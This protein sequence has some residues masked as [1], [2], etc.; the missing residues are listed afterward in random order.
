MGNN[1]E[2]TEELIKDIK[3]AVDKAVGRYSKKMNCNFYTIGADNI[4]ISFR[5]QDTMQIDW[6]IT[7]N[8]T[9]RGD[10]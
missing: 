10:G 3:E 4:E 9:K 6:K 7:A 1:K 5:T 2:Y 8:L